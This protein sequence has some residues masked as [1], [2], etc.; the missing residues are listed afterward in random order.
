MAT[1]G[2]GDIHPVT[3]LEMIY[4]IIAQVG[5]CGLFSYILGSLGSMLDKNETIIKEF[6]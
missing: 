1:I 3:E 6:K 2:Y 5:A 4:V